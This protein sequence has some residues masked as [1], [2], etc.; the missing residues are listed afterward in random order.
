MHQPL[1]E[2]AEAFRMA[3]HR[4]DKA[5]GAD[6]RLWRCNKPAISLILEGRRRAVLEDCGR[7]LLLRR[8]AGCQLADI[9][10]RL[11]HHRPWQKQPGPV[12]LGPGHLGHLGSG[13][14]CVGFA[15]RGKL[16]GIGLIMRLTAPVD[17]AVDSADGGHRFG[18]HAIFHGT[19]SRKVL[20]MAVQSDLQA[21]GLGA[22]GIAVSG[23]FMRQIDHETRIAAGR[24]LADAGC[25]DKDD[26]IPAAKLQ[27][28]FGSRK[29]GEP[30]TN[31]QP[32]SRNVSLGLGIGG[33]R[34]QDRVPTGH[35]RIAR[36]SGDLSF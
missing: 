4:H 32:V 23:Q 12:G 5:P 2:E 24:P 18:R 7:T 6:P 27:K 8:Q 13:Q 26:A 33:R 30:A 35:T 10:G 34:V 1:P 31:D 3:I 20:R 16:V 17:G 11:Q 22:S 9:K 15:K 28:T 21:I 14:L 19:A 36:Q 29:P 25:L